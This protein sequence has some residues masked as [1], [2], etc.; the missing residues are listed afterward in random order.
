MKT[1]LKT[2]IS[3]FL[4]D[5]HVLNETLTDIGTEISCI[6]MDL[7][8]ESINN[9]DL[10]GLEG[11]QLGHTLDLSKFHKVAILEFVTLVLMNSDNQ[12]I[13]LSCINNNECLSILTICISDAKI[14]AIVKEGEACGT[15]VLGQDEPDIF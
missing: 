11:V 1:L 9:S 15:I 12:W 3:N 5:F 14:V 13:G 7:K 6:N 4:R 8:A 2:V 10:S